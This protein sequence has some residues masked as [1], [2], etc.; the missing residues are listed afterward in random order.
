MRTTIAG[1]LYHLFQ[2]SFSLNRDDFDAD[3]NCSL[4]FNALN[5]LTKIYLFDNIAMLDRELSNQLTHTRGSLAQTP[6]CCGS[7]KHT[8][9]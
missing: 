3:G 1:V 8:S 6:E 4:A 2:L 9:G 7:S 5:K